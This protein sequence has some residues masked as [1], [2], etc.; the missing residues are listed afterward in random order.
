MGDFDITSIY[1]VFLRHNLGNN[2]T[3][4]KH[5][6]IFKTNQSFGRSIGSFSMTNLLKKINNQLLFTTT[7]EGKGRFTKW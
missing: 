4:R 1:S 5:E 2:Q 7:E 3:L 6:S